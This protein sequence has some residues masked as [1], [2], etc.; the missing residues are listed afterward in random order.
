VGVRSGVRLQ[1]PGPIESRTRPPRTESSSPV[2]VRTA[3]RHLDLK[4]IAPLTLARHTRVCGAVHDRLVFH[5]VQP[6]G[7]A[8][9]RFDSLEIHERERSEVS[10]SVGRFAMP[11]Q[12]RPFW[13]KL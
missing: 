1:Q 7:C 6:L 8:V 9:G 12:P 11:R 4:K 5:A 2:N 3:W 13:V 10:H